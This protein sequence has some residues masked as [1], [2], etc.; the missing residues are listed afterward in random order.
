MVNIDFHYMDWNTVDFL[1]SPFMKESKWQVLKDMKTEFSFL[2]VLSL[3]GY[4]TNSE[5]EWL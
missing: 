1:L 3:Y 5:N 2:D 4:W